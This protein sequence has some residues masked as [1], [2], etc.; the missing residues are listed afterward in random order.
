MLFN[1][2]SP[3]NFISKQFISYRKTTHVRPRINRKK[4][5]FFG[6]FT[7]G[8]YLPIKFFKLFHSTLKTCTI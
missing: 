8:Y 3:L 7:L 6:L 2:K 4:K 1:I 5:S